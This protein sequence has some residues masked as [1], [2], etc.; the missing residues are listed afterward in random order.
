MTTANPTSTKGDSQ[1]NI[2][3]S[4]A[5]GLVLCTD[6]YKI[7]EQLLQHLKNEQAFYVLGLNDS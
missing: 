1:T 7:S 6:E 3:L 2:D 5:D 4:F